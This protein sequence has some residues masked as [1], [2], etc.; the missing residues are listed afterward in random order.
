MEFPNQL[1]Y[2]RGVAHTRNSTAVLARPEQEIIGW[3]YA[4]LDQQETPDAALQ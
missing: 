1:D 2:L 3:P 4:G